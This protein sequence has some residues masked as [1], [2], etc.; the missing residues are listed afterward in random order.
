MAPVSR[1]SFVSVPMRMLVMIAMLP[2]SNTCLLDYKPI[3]SGVV[4]VFDQYANYCICIS[5]FQV[6]GSY[7]TF[8]ISL[9]L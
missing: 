8:K 7:H 6:Y 9:L 1:D 2:V 3:A 5:F 4:L